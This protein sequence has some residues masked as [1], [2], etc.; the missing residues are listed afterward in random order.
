M[1]VRLVSGLGIVS[2]FATL[3]SGFATLSSGSATLS[4]GS[5]TAPASPIGGLLVALR[6][7]PVLAG[8]RIAI[9]LQLAVHYARLYPWAT[10]LYSDQGMLA[11]PARNPVAL[12]LSPLYHLDAPWMIQTMVLGLV[13]LSLAFA[14]GL[15]TRT[16]GVLLALGATAL[17]HRNML[18][19]NPSLPYLGFWLLAQAFSRPNPPWSIDRWRAR[20]AGATRFGFADRLPR[21][22]LGALWVVY[23]VGY[24][25]SGYTKLLSP[26]WADGSA[27]ARMLRGPI[28]LDNP[29]AHAVAALPDPVLTAAT[30]GVVGLELL[31]APLALSRRLRPALWVALLGMHAGLLGLVGLQDITWGMLVTHLALFDPRWLD[32]A[33]GA[34]PTAR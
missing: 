31:A 32:R 27:V 13:A 30:W 28:A 18:T 9:G 14:A 17:W 29:L 21:D 10:T 24:S 22:V 26:S 16:A 33:R 25:F 20:R 15:W 34:R 4:S 11:D 3:S 19:L 12:G 6:R 7:A 23:T 8:V 5:A 2:G 1:L